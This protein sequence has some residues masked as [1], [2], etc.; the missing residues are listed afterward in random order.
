MFWSYGFGLAANTLEDK[1]ESNRTNQVIEKEN[2][3]E[4][5]I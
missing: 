4:N 5:N 2:I 3:W 1:G